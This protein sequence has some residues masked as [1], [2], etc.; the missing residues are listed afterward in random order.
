MPSGATGV[1]TTS[2]IARAQLVVL[3]DDFE[4]NT[5]TTEAAVPIPC[6]RTAHDFRAVALGALNPYEGPPPFHT[7]G[8]DTSLPGDLR[9]VKV[10][11]N[12]GADFLRCQRRG[13]CLVNP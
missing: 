6:M 5:A 1:N 2:V 7:L 9:G 10:K 12:K 8:L 13:I 11:T 3:T 4:A